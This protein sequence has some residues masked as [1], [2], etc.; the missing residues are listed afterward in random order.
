MI[1]FRHLGQKYME[2]MPFERG[3]DYFFGFLG[4]KF[5]INEYNCVLYVQTL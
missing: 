5:V 1:W 2:E 4:M 3:Y